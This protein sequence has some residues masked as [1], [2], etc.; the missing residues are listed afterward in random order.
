MTDL[1]R[2]LLRVGGWAD[3]KTL[4]HS[5]I[6]GLTESYGIQAF[7]ERVL[8]TEPLN[9]IRVSAAWTGAEDAIATYAYL[10][11]GTGT[12]PAV[13][14]G[15]LAFGRFWESTD[16][17]A[18]VPRAGMFDAMTQYHYITGTFNAERTG[19]ELAAAVEL[20]ARGVGEHWAADLATRG[21]ATG[22]L[23]QLDDGASPEY[24]DA[25]LKETNG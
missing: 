9:L 7:P 11:R 22:Y 8:D 23:A 12:E 5:V 24:L 3:G 16:F 1:S 17:S 4:Q 13:S 2:A 10:L 20:H 25:I 15:A 14:E 21:E 19:R 18:V 6:R